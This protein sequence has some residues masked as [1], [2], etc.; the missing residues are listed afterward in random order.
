MFPFF[1]LFL[2]ERSA[3]ARLVVVCEATHLIKVTPSY[4]YSFLM[5]C[6]LRAPVPCT[7]RQG[8]CKEVI[9]LYPF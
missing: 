2:Y 3:L 6:F 1:L 7:G 8:A 9:N 5:D 4:L